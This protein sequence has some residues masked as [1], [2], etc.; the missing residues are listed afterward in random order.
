MEKPSPRSLIPTFRNEKE[1]ITRDIKSAKCKEA[2][3][4]R[5]DEPVAKIETTSA[6]LFPIDKLIYSEIS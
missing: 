5:K 6:S 4:D 3:L 1:N 2:P